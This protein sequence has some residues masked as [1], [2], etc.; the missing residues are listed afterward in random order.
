MADAYITRRGGGSSEAAVGSKTVKARVYAD[1]VE[2]GEI[3]RFGVDDTLY[4][5]ANE[6]FMGAES[7]FLMSNTIPGTTDEVFVVRPVGTPTSAL[8]HWTQFEFAKCQIVGEKLVP[9]VDWKAVSISD[10]G[11]QKGIGLTTVSNNTAFSS[12][13]LSYLNIKYYPIYLIAIN[14]YLCVFISYS[15]KSVVS[16]GYSNNVPFINDLTLVLSLDSTASNIYNEIASIWTNSED[17]SLHFMS[18]YNGTLKVHSVYYT[19]NGGEADSVNVIDLTTLKLSTD[20]TYLSRISIINS[21]SLLFKTG[22]GVVFKLNSGLTG[23]ISI[24]DGVS[25]DT[26]K[27]NILDKLK[28]IKIQSRDKFYAYNDQPRKLLQKQVFKQNIEVLCF[29]NISGGFYNSGT[30]SQNM[31]TR[32]VIV[33]ISW[34]NPTNPVL[35]KEELLMTSYPMN[36]SFSALYLQIQANKLVMLQAFAVVDSPSVTGI[37]NDFWSIYST[38]GVL[39]SEVDAAFLDDDLNIISIPPLT[40]FKGD[41]QTIQNSNIPNN[42]TNAWKYQ[43][44]LNLVNHTLYAACCYNF[45]NFM[46]SI[47]AEANT[48]TPAAADYRELKYRAIE[49]AYYGTHL[50]IPP[51]LALS[52]GDNG[53]EIE[54]Q[55]LV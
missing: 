10:V 26:F 11:H 38:T 42:V 3:V 24:Y 55:V 54:V 14:E 8:T 13:P 41:Y 4:P 20:A 18:Y 51:G 45:G 28:H 7:M 6:S 43:G 53:E 12:F 39:R 31:R 19:D 50:A 36:D 49:P 34:E 33:V 16:F 21:E 40:L 1:E 30:S 46:N 17:N 48:P 44:T 52:S 47:G 5:S 9:K 22:N 27:T 23:I 25:A 2:A 35:I 37:M 32:C 15:S 29:W